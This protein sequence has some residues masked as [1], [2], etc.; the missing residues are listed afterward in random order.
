MATQT[1]KLN[2]KTGEKEGK[3][4]WDR[5][6]VLFVHTDETGNITSI[7]VRHSMFPGVEMVAFPKRTDDDRV[8]E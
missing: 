3:T 8:T 5:C 4:F 6:G 7:Q 1:L 2:V